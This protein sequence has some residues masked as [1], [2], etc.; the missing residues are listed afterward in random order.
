MFQDD[1]PASSRAFQDDAP[2]SSRASDQVWFSML[3]LN[4]PNAALFGALRPPP[5]HPLLAALRRPFERRER[6][7][8]SPR[9][10][11]PAAWGVARRS[12]LSLWVAAGLLLVGFA[13]AEAILEAVTASEAPKA[14]TSGAARVGA[15]LIDARALRASTTTAAPVASAAPAGLVRGLGAVPAPSNATRA[16]EPSE[17]TG[18]LTAAVTGG[19]TR[20][21]GAAP[22][23]RSGK[24][25]TARASVRA[26]AAKKARNVRRVRRLF[27]SRSSSGR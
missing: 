9:A 13:S 4:D 17:P 8:E 7:A 15:T 11:A 24:A 2:A 3:L 26:A 14:A 20:S 16:H 1:V 27:A 23:A 12:R 25:A 21:F 10:G 22:A 5:P 19:A 6:A 18:S